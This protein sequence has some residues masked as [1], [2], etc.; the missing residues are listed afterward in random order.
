MLIDHL[1][2]ARAIRVRRD[3]LEH[4]RGGAVRERAIHDVGMASDP[5]DI[6]RA[7]VHFARLVVEHQF[8]RETGPDHVPARGVQRA[9]RLSGAAGGVQNEQRVFG[10]HFLGRA[11]GRGGGNQCLIGVVATFLHGH[12]AAR[13]GHHDHGSDAR[14]CLEREVS[15]G[16]QCHGAPPT[17]ALVGGDEHAGAGVLDTVGQAVRGEAAK[18]DGMDRADAGTGQHGDGGLDHHRQ[19]D[20]D[21]VAFFHAKGFQHVGEAAYLAVQ[22]AIGDV[23]A[24]VGVVAFPDDRDLVA[25]R[26]EMAVEAAGGG[27]QRAVAEPLDPD[28]PGEVASER[29]GGMLDP[30][31]APGFLKPEPGGIGFRAGAHGGVGVG[32]V[33][34]PGRDLGF[35]G[36]ELV[37]IF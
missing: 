2:E 19:V 37:H 7:P 25:A 3:A 31:D 5:A 34:G 18:H 12:G 4:Q 1:P 24:Y 16:L 26:G 15:V 11:I 23:P 8:M 27:I 17:A 28:V 20:R 29:L 10:G 30:G 14:A 21:P 13:D 36:D 32:G 33:A 22:L 9:F 6:G 35:Y